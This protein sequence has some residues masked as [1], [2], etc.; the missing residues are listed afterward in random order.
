MTDDERRELGAI[1]IALD[2][3]CSHLTDQG[4]VEEEQMVWDVHKRIIHLLTYD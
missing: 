1:G 2:I 3:I 4:L